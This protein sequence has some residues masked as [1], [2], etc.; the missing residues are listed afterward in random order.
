MLEKLKQKLAKG[1]NQ[2]VFVYMFSDLLAKGIP[3]LL[4]PIYTLYLTP[5]QFGNIAVFNIIVEIM[6]IFVIMGGNSYYR[7]QYFKTTD[8]ETLLG[9]IVSN[10]V[11]TIPVALLLSSLFIFFELDPTKHSSFWLYTALIIAVSQSVVLLALALFQCQGSALFIGIINLSSA[12]IAGIA[13]VV[14]LQFGYKEEARYIAYLVASLIAMLLSFYI[15]KKSQRRWPKLTQVHCKPALSFGF[16]V[17]PHAL[18][19]WA[20]TG[21][22]RVIIAKFISVYQVGLYSIAAQLSLIVIV[23]SNAVNQ[24]FTPKIMQMLSEEKYGQTVKLCLKV[25]VIY[26]LICS[27]IALASP[28]IFKLFINGKFIEAQALL[29]LLC[30]VAFFQAVVTLLSNFL[31]FFKQV[32]LLSSITFFTSILHVVIAFSIV[33]R[34]GVQGIIWSS[35]LTYILSAIAI[36]IVAMRSI[37]RT[38]YAS[39]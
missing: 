34:Y 33:E 32:K 25:I 31:Y 13:T 30:V 12:A 3:F 20:R 29:P 16:G 19:W 35:I 14:L 1:E 7:V 5:T 36:S 11:V 6:I 24:A 9:S 38:H 21:M 8:K 37:K 28:L 2:N 18:S 4:I 39:N 23:F 26:F 10:F 17:L 27:G 15:Y 22:D